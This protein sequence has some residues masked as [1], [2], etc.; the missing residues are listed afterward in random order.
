[1]RERQR[2]MKRNE[3]KE[4]DWIKKNKERGGRRGRDEEMRE[5]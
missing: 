1:M 2:Q 3:K 4:K 5:S